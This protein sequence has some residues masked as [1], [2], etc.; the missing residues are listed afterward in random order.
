MEESCRSREF[1]GALLTDHDHG[2][3]IAKLEAYGF[4]KEA[5]SYILSYLSSRKHRI[6]VNNSLSEW[7]DIYFR[8]TTG[9]YTWTSA[10]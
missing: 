8:G 7:A 10:F 3:L 9:I 2:L 4:E 5:L 6:K 1:A